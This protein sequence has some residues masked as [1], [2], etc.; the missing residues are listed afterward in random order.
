MKRT[1]LRRV[2]KK[3]AAADRVYTVNRRVCL[4]RAGHRC[5]AYI[6]GVCTG[7]A[8]V[9]HHKLRRSQGGGHDL[10]NLAAL[11]D[12]CHR[13]LHDNPEVGYRYGLLIPRWAA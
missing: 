13:F 1:S 11:C 3:K 7:R 6:E 10:D 8:E 12:A 9:V 5:E 4:E 2:S